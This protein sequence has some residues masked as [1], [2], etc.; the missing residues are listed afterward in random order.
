MSE[1]QPVNGFEWLEDFSKIDGDVIKNYD[2]E[3]DQG[4]ILKVDIEYSKHLYDLH[5]DLPFLLKRMKIDKCTK[6]VCNLYNKESYV[7]H[8]RSLKQA[9]DH[10]LILKKVHR[11]I[12]FNQKAWFKT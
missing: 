9:L 11:V 6:V 12:L 1:P 2:K 3:S 8:I 7:V 5:S 10:M 4:Y